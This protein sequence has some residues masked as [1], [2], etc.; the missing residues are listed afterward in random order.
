[1][2]ANSVAPGAQQKRFAAYLDR[3]AQAAGHLDRVVPLK[4]Y[5]TGLLLPGERKS[6]E[7]MAARLCPDN[8]RQTHQSLHHVVAHA[9]WRDEDILEAVRHYAL[10]AMQKQAPIKAWVVDDTGLVK[11]GT[12]SVGV[13]RQYCGQV[14]KQ[15]NCRV[16]VSLSISTA[17]ASL[18]IAWR[19]YLPEVWSEDQKRRK[20]TGVPP[21]ISFQTKPEIALRQLRTAVDRGIPRAPVLADAAYGNDTKFRDGITQL[22]LLYVMGVQSSV[23]VWPPG[24]APLPKRKWKGI[25]RPTTLLQRDRRHRPVSVR[26]LAMSLPFSAWKTVR[27]RE[28]TG[29][30]LRARFAALRIRPAHRDDW[31]SEPRAEEWLLI[32][33]P[34]PEAEPIKY[35]LSTLPENMKLRDLVRLAKHRWIVERDYQEL[36]QELGLG[37]YEGRGWRGFH[38][39]AT[40]CIA[41]YGFLVAER[42][43]FSPSARAGQV[44]LPVPKMPR[45]FRPRGSPGAR[46]A[47]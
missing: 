21:E 20:T 25:G 23:S 8:V 43:R 39:H 33:G 31:R 47:A 45:Q 14:G 41:A 44:D 11:K 15:E 38:H 24:R 18:P 35:W 34:S 32:E 12:H 5:C 28:G 29:E 36:K 6:V 30:P 2:S 27:W 13:T 42:S 26:E 3:L 46:G 19:L 1:M 9:P 16:A 22:G 40:L 17:A 7:P 4:S 37:H 10:P